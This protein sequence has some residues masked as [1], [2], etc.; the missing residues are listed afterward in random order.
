MTRFSLRILKGLFGTL[1]Y[2]APSLAGSMAF[3]LFCRT[4]NPARLTD[5][6]KRV[7]ALSRD[8]MRGARKHPLTTEHGD[9][10]AY[11]F[12]N[13]G[14]RRDGPAV[15]VLHGWRSRTEHMRVI[16]EALLKRGFRVVSLDL[17]GHGA[18]GGRTLNIPKAV[19]AVNAVAQ[20]FGP[21]DAMVGHSFGGAVAVNA[22]AGS[23]A[24]VPPVPARRLVSIAA[25]NALPD[26]FS[27]FGRFA[28][29]GPASQK[30]FEGCVEKIA[31]APVNA[32]VGAQQLQ[33]LEIPTLVVHAPEDKEVSA[34]DARALAGSGAHVSLV[35]APGFG[36]RRILAD[37]GIAAR[38]AAFVSTRQERRLEG[39]TART[40]EDCLPNVD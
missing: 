24:G 17:P 27:R 1:E 12:T 4:P 25:P 33:D 14:G 37:P 35:W 10:V 7:L 13:W 20:W 22:I 11:E 21:F 2:V 40:L 19:A 30:A 39:E 28:G 29:L 6:E 3:R 38:V 5:K 8:F 34:S 9:V 16:V 26:L 36:H 15:L 18:S 32:F 31:G 23:V